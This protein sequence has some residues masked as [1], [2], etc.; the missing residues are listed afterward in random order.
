MNAKVNPEMVVL[1]REL[2]ELTQKELAEA[3]SLTQATI[4]RYES[5]LVE[6]PREHVAVLAKVLKR[7]ES[8][9]YWPE[10][11]RGA[12]DSFH[13]KLKSLLVRE[14]NVI[15]ARVNF[16]RLQTARLLR[17]AKVRSNYSFHRLDAATYGGP[18]GCAQQ[19]R[20]L[21]QLPAGP[22]RNLVNA[23]EA[24]GGVVFRCSFGT[25]KADGVSQWP[26]DDDQMPPVF[27]V[28]EE[29]PG[30]RERWTLA[31]EIGHIV[32]HHLPAVDPEGE[33]DRF[34]SEF[35][36]P[37]AEIEPSLSNMTLPKAAELKGYWK[38]SMQ[39]IIYRAYQLNKISKE[40]YTQLFRQIYAKHY[41]KCEP[42]PIPAEEPALFVQLARIQR[43]RFRR[44]DSEIGEI[45]GETAEGIRE[46]YWHIFSNVRLT[47]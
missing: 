19:L 18:E 38:A 32:M 22:V 14:M 35:L 11:R 9:F 15:T 2:L 28:R 23:I 31:H 26:L 3:V 12:T 17:Y 34:A 43:T 20:R 37:A 1:A 13:R 5:G 21:W 42:V 7:P 25:E 46:N 10:R 36:M 16:L 47:P 27:F 24:A 29:A 45:M 6:V 33:A 8:F 30:D 39:A 41:H 40:K 44:N 4:S